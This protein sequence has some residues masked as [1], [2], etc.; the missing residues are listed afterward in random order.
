MFLHNG[1]PPTLFVFLATFTSSVLSI[2]IKLLIFLLEVKVIILQ[3]SSFFSFLSF[4]VAVVVF[5]TE[6][7]LHLSY[8]NAVGTTSSSL[9]KRQIAR[10]LFNRKPE[11]NENKEKKKELKKKDWIFKKKRD[12]YLANVEQET[13]FL[14]L[15]ESFFSSIVQCMCPP[16]RRV[17]LLM[18]LTHPTGHY[19]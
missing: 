4:F 2:L 12:F 11:M 18:Y 13:A 19:Q 10:L 8:L 16:F 7:F 15:K 3:S 14:F 6:E 1:G 9:K 5:K 17:C